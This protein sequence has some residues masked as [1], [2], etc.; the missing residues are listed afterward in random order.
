MA[1]RPPPSSP[2]APVLGADEIDAALERLERRIKELEAFEPEKS[3]PDNPQIGILERT[4]A[5]TLREIFGD[6]TEEFYQYSAARHLNTAPISVGFRSPHS[7][8]IVGLIKGKRRAIETLRQAQKN[9]TEKLEFTARASTAPRQRAASSAAN[10]RDVFVTH[11]HDEAAREAVA[12][13]LEKAGFNPIILHEQANRG[14]TVIEKI[15]R[16]SDVGFAVVLLTPDDVGGP[17]GS[18]QKARAR[19]NVIAEL[20]YFVGKLGR[21]RVA[22]LVKG[23]IEIP[24]NI[25]G[26][27]YTD[28]DGPGAWRAA[29]LRELEAAG[30]QVDW[31]ALR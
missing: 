7:E 10:T 29:L 26:V 24:S 4:I 12:R 28:L 16:Y 31:S 2:S 9:L 19:Q 27:V 13:F 30:Y 17:A 23:T 15:E 5:G 3:D 22:A 18:A 11:G 21:S 14:D 25:G 6:K 20:F 1:R 8:I